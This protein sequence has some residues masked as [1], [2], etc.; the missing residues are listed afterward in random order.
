MHCHQLEPA[1]RPTSLNDNACRAAAYGRS[2]VGHGF[3]PSAPRFSDEGVG[4]QWTACHVAAQSDGYHIAESP[5]FLF[6]DDGVSGRAS[7]RP[8]LDRLLDV[9]RSG[10]APFSRLYIT[11][12]ARLSRNEV[13]FSFLQRFE[14]ELASHGIELRFL[15]DT[16]ALADV[17][18]LCDSLG[19]AVNRPTER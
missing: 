5:D 12:G 8:E 11:D 14:N 6:G 2:A 1:S 9:V 19:L 18:S 10:H 16:N 15:T 13:G 7:R 3:A 17:S 4:A